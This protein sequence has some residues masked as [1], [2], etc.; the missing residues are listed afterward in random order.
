MEVG[1]LQNVISAGEQLTVEFKSD[2]SG[3]RGE[4][5]LEDETILSEAV[6]LANSGGGYLLI[7]VEDDGEVTA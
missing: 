7:G 5:A 1:M 2:R 6:A 4:H 3:A